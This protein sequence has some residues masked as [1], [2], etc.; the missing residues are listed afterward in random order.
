VKQLAVACLVALAACGSRD[1]FECATSAQCVRG[2][3]S[4]VCVQNACAFPDPGCPSGYRFEPNANGVGGTCAMVMVDAAGSAACGGIGEACC[5]AAPVCRDLA[6]TSGMCTAC[7]VDVALGRRFNCVLRPDH[8]IWC[9][10][11]NTLGQLGLGIAGMPSATRVQ[12]HAIDTT[13]I[14]DATAVGAGRDHA[15]AVRANGTVWCWGKNTAGQL[16]DNTNV[17]KSAAVQV[18]KAGNVPLTNIVEIEAGYVST[19]ARDNAG[20]VWCWGGNAKGQLG[21]N[22]N[23]SRSTAAPVIDATAATP[24]TGSTELVAGGGDTYCSRTAATWYC[25]GANDNGQLVDGTIANH[26]RPFA[27]PATTSLAEGMYHSCWLNADTTVTCGG[28][29]GHGRLG[30]GSTGFWDQSNHTASNTVLRADGSNFTGAKQLVA[31]ALTCA[32]MTDSTVQ[33]WGDDVHGQSG[34]AEGSPYPQPVKFLDGTTLTGVDRVLSRYAH[35][36]ANRTTGEWFCWGRNGQ[37]ELADGSFVN[38]GYP[39]PLKGACQ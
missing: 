27:M 12:V 20:G 21:D 30:T 23:T 25:W 10:G 29:A 33:C 11:E 1:A 31:G 22:T 16:G 36:C 37:G 7:N 35:T 3:E 24:L 17:N 32:L 14:A 18:V 34:N 4:G 26:L 6:C 38:R 28:W 2:T 9:A 13:L 5:Q 15:C 19:C 8:T 39:I